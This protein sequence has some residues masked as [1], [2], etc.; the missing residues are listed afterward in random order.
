MSGK[1]AKILD[2]EQLKKKEEETARQREAAK[3]AERE[4]DAFEKARQ[5]RETLSAEEAAKAQA[6]RLQEEQAAR[7]R[8]VLAEQQR[9]KMEEFERQKQA[10]AQRAAQEKVFYALAL[11]VQAEE[12]KRA[13]QEAFARMEAARK[14][15]LEEELARRKLADAERIAEEKARDEK[16][17]RQR[18]AM[19][20]FEEDQRLKSM[21]AEDR[22]N[23]LALRR[24]KDRIAKEKRE[25]LEQ[26]KE[27]QTAGSQKQVVV[28]VA[29]AV[30]SQNVEVQTAAFQKQ[31]V[32]VTPVAISQ[33]KE[34]K[35]AA[36]QKQAVVVAPVV[37]SV[38][39]RDDNDDAVL[40]IH[41]DPDS[42][43]SLPVAT[44]PPEYSQRPLP[45]M[46][47]RP[48]PQMP[49]RPLPDI[50]SDARH[51]K[52]ERDRIE[53]KQRE[54]DARVERERQ[55]ALERL[56]Q[57]RSSVRH[58]ESMQPSAGSLAAELPYIPADPPIHAPVAYPAESDLDLLKESQRTLAQIERSE[59]SSLR[60]TGVSPS[61]SIARIPAASQAGGK[62]SGKV[63]DDSMDSNEDAIRRIQQLNIGMGRARLKTPPPKPVARD[64]PDD[65][66]DDGDD[67]EQTL[68]PASVIPHE[69]LEINLDD[70]EEL[71]REYN[72]IR[73]QSL[74][75]SEASAAAAAG[76][77]GYG[78][79]LRSKRMRKKGK[80]GKGDCAVM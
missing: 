34:V 20:R 70:E 51:S 52:S 61:L 28:V 57:E 58:A 27:V 4:R 7:Q 6:A 30:I 42:P 24:E 44:E 68:I 67:T 14:Q 62:L 36:P 41:A 75:E 5:L 9:S 50:P 46:P 19:K 65:A 45:Q 10:A 73:K 66:V 2:F 17:A 37:I 79:G 47:T 26:K 55:A 69:K 3:V 25:A 31:A 64:Q 18:E 23:F 32:V 29:P 1:E 22:E 56:K 33:K 38:A 40:K 77:M 63:Y 15:K 60:A 71:D 80:K 16:L 39:D 12:A 74:I 11:T 35:P 21:S 48:L 59:S 49:T 8:S 72:R 76:N 53:A 43:P 54:M 13:E 78:Q